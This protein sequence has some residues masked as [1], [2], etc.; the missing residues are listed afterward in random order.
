[1]IIG[2]AGRIGS[3]KDTLGMI[4]QALTMNTPYG[5]HWYSEPLEYVKAY[6]GRPNV[7][8]GWQIK[9]YADKL[10]QIAGILLGVSPEK[11]EDRAFKDSILGP[12]WDYWTVEGYYDNEWAGKESGR[13]F[14]SG[15]DALGFAILCEMEA[16]TPVNHYQMTVR[17]FLQNLGTEAIRG[18]LHQN[19]WINALFA[20]YKEERIHHY[21]LA[22]LV[23]TD[24]EI[25][26]SMKYPDWIV[27]DVRFPDEARA[28]KHRGGI[29]VQ[30][31][32][33]DNPYPVSNHRTEIGLDSWKFDRVIVNTSLE[34][35]LEQA[36]EV[37]SITK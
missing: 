31:Q 16:D 37:L 28:I 36:K 5:S 10:R 12:E 17:E 11:F 6:K 26:Y 33:P 18:G 20:D 25:D 13:T 15:Q 7:K 30:V 23:D 27:T 32:R 9:K 3:G 19:A 24:V 2:I 34:V 35:L 8:G 1:M 21:T 22:E 14:P 4:L 29:I